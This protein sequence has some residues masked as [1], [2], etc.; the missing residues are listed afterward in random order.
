MIPGELRTPTWHDLDLICAAVDVLDELAADPDAAD[1]R[2]RVYDFSIRWGVLLAGRL[3]RLEHY[4][5]AGALSGEEKARY[6]ALVQRLRDA[7][8]AARRLGL[9]APRLADAP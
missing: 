3:R 5:A 9:T 4:D 6:D 7:T 2:A 1:D 8:P